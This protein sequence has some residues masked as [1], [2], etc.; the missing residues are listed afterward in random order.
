[1]NFY[2]LYKN[3]INENNDIF[4]KPL[5]IVIINS[6]PSEGIMISN[7]LKKSIKNYFKIKVFT[8]KINALSYI[9]R[10]NTTLLI[11][12]KNITSLQNYNIINYKKNNNE[13]NNNKILIFDKNLM[14]NN[15]IFFMN[16][17]NKFK[18]KKKKKILN[19]NTTQELWKSI[20]Y[21]NAINNKYKNIIFN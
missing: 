18:F 7:L 15:F 3:I 5:R 11:T 10:K 16:I 9:M 13:N 8:N 17:L 4:L 14:F 19:Y 1:M 6:S 2:N 20:L 12:D 21:K